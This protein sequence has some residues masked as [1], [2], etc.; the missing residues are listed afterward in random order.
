MEKCPDCGLPYTTDSAEAKAACYEDEFCAERTIERLR[1]ALAER[2]RRVAEL[3]ELEADFKLWRLCRNCGSPPRVCQAS[4]I[5]C[6]PDCTHE[7]PQRPQ[8]SDDGGGD[9]KDDKGGP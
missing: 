3:E 5:K 6:C 9:S 4:R 2:D 7:L 1:A 8:D